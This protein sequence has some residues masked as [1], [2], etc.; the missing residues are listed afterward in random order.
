[1]VPDV[2]SWNYNHL[3]TKHS[4]NMSYGLKL[5]NPK[6]Y[7]HE[8]HRPTHFLTFQQAAADMEEGADRED[9]FA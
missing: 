1:M 9:H 4:E 5:E 7:Y 2:G 3:G 8:V 6:E